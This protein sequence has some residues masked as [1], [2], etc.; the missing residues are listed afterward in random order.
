MTETAQKNLLLYTAE[1]DTSSNSDGS[2]HEKKQSKSS[3]QQDLDD[4][5]AIS[6]KTQMSRKYQTQG[7]PLYKKSAS[8]SSTSSST[9]S[10]WTEKK[11]QKSLKCIRDSKYEAIKSEKTATLTVARNRDSV[12]ICDSTRT[13]KDSIKMH[14][15]ELQHDMIHALNTNLH[16]LMLKNGLL[17]E[18]NDLHVENIDRLN[19][20]LTQREKSI[21]KKNESIQGLKYEIEELEST[22][23]ASKTRASVHEAKNSERDRAR[24]DQSALQQD[25][26]QELKAKNDALNHKLTEKEDVILDKDASIKM[27]ND[28]INESIKTIRNLSKN[29]HK[30]Q[31]KKENAIVNKDQTIK[32]LKIELKA[33]N[34]KKHLRRAAIKNLKKEVATKNAEMKELVE[35]KGKFLEN[36]GSEIAQLRHL[37]GD[38]KVECERVHKEN[39]LLKLMLKTNEQPVTIVI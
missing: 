33:S 36:K 29:M 5:N 3:L 24:M 23:L 22:L 26:I 25:M 30:S 14:Q 2:I 19:E 32:E 21:L 37:L 15:F 13:E 35:S 8:F 6:S 20:I 7:E 1:D 11:T 31:T 27:L 9:S 39:K 12:R 10:S 18:Q 28:Q 17:Q 16:E 4:I 34:A 38:F